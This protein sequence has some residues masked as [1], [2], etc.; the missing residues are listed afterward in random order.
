MYGRPGPAKPFGVRRPATP[1]LLRFERI[2]IKARLLY[3]Y[4]LVALF[5]L[6]PYR[7]GIS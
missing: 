4:V 3:E 5:G 6:I 7:R 1:A 2:A